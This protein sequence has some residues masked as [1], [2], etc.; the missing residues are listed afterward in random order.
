MGIE[1]EKKFLLANDDWRQQVVKSIKFRQGYL[2]GSDKASV[3]VRIQGD[4]A[5]INIKSMVSPSRYAKTM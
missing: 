4:Q 2:V 1:I 3:R 5:N